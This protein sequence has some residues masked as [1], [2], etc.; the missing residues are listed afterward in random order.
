M[1]IISNPLRI[2][3]KVWYQET[4]RGLCRACHCPGLVRTAKLFV[5]PSHRLQIAVSFLA[6]V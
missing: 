6:D 2:N 1:N 4:F 5:F 3:Y